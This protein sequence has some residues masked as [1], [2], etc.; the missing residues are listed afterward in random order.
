MVDIIIVTA[1]TTSAIA[2]ITSLVTHIRYSNCWG[3]SCRTR[4]DNSPSMTPSDI[5]S[6][7]LLHK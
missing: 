5:K 7:L 6:P 4:G 1:L 3:G 2:L